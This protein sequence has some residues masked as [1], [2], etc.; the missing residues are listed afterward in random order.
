MGVH[1]PLDHCTVTQINMSG[2]VSTIKLNDGAAIPWLAWGNGTGNA[3]KQALDAGKQALQ[4]GIDHIDTAQIYTTEPET[5]QAIQETKT[6]REKVWV[7]SKIFKPEETDEETIASI[8]SSL[9]KL[10]GTPELY[11][12]HNPFLDNPDRVL[13]TWRILEKL[14]DEG[15]LKSIGVS[16]F[17]PKDLELILREGKHKPAVNQLEFHPF[18]LK[19]LEPVLKIQKEHGIITESYGPLTPTL[20]HPEKGGG[21]LAPVLEKVAEAVSKRAGKEL[22][23]NAVLLLWCK[24]HDVV[25]VTAS[26]NAERIKGLAALAKLDVNLTKEEVDEIDA[27]G[28][29]Y[30][31]RYYTEHMTTDFPEPDLPKD[32]IFHVERKRSS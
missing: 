24:A 29:E 2:S 32:N 3:K 10:G 12:I 16:N 30:H 23:S 22:D 19:H 8:Q 26:A 27:E 20:R 17:R 28:S 13:P 11:L 25:A 21:P 14:K 18:V 15:K 5:L 4:A 31:F 1:I 6:P 7:T 9:D